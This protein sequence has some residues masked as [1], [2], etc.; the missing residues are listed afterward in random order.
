MS[1]QHHDAAINF[2]RVLVGTV[3]FLGVLIGGLLGVFAAAGLC[4]AIWGSAVLDTALGSP[5][6]RHHPA[7]WVFMA[8]MV[9]GMLVGMSGTF[10]CCYLPLCFRWPRVTSRK[11]SLGGPILRWLQRYS[12]ALNAYCTQELQRLEPLHDNRT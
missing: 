10:F 4:A 9:P 6:E 11:A 5:P 3:G 7:F 2:R 8:V 1:N 12:T